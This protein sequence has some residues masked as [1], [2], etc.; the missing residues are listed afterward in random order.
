LSN[1]KLADRLPALLPEDPLHWADAWLKEAF[2]ANAQRNPNSMTVATVAA[3]GQPSAR[4]VLC[5][6]IVPDPGYLVFY[7]NYGSQKSLQIA[8]N[9]K[10]AAVLHWDALGRQVRIEG[11]AVRSPDE[12]NDAYF[13]TRDWGSRLGAWGSDQSKEIE[14]RDALAAQ[15]RERGIALGLN[16]DGDTQALAEGTIPQI[17]RPPHWGGFRLWATAVE[18]WIEGGDRIHD[19]ARWTRDVIRGSNNG[20][21]TTT[22]SGRRLQP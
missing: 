18:L 17:E 6:D 11:I 22:W 8:E 14:S 2:A 1:E 9:P 21:S 20:F 4:V 15:I 16:F 10:I 5:K 13:A 7:T 12:E 19:R 3:N